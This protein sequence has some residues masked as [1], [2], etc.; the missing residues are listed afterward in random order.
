MRSGESPGGAETGVD[1]TVRRGEHATERRA[2]VRRRN[3][4]RPAPKETRV[5]G[6]FIYLYIYIIHDGLLRVGLVTIMT[7]FPHVAQHVEQPEIVG[8]QATTRLSAVARCEIV[9]GVPPQQV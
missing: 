8:Q 2:D 9:P 5:S 1:A 7:P 3:E 6:I 4:E